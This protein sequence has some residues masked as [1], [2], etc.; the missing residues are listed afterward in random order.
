MQG[1]H[2]YQPGCRKMA[3]LGRTRGMR[4]V[5]SI[6]LGDSFFG[7]P[8]ATQG[9]ARQRAGTNHRAFIEGRRAVFG[10]ML[11]GA[12]G[13]GTPAPLSGHLEFHE[14]LRFAEDELVAA[15]A[16]FFL[17]DDAIAG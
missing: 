15:V 16:G 10:D 11:L 17:S 1:S 7:V 13:D 9:E 12:C 8:S 3:D 2:K 14:F 5:K 4:R 6:R